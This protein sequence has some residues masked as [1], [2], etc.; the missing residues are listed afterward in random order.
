MKATVMCVLLVFLAGATASA[1]QDPSDAIYDQ[2]QVATFGLTMDRASWDAICYD[3]AGAGDQWHRAEMTWQS[4]T[5]PGVGVK[6]SG[7]GTR[8]DRTPKPAIRISFNEFEYSNPAGPG[9]PGR[10]WRGVNRIK[11]DNGEAGDDRAMMR[12]RVAYGLFRGIGAPAPRT[13]HARLYV[14]GSYIGLFTVEEPVRKDFLRYHRG[15]DSGNLYNVY[16]WV[17]GWNGT[18]PASYV[19]DPWVAETNYPGGDYTDVVR[20]CDVINNASLDQ[21]RARLANVI[22]VDG[23]LRHLAVEKVIVDH[24]GVVRLSGGTNNHFWY[25]RAATDRLE[26][27]KWDPGASQ[28]LGDETVAIDHNFDS[29]P[30][31]RWIRNDAAAWDAYK[32]WIRRTLDGPAAGIQAR[33]D[34]IYDQIKSHA[35]EDTLKGISATWHPNGF[36]NAEF[37]QGVVDLK[38][39]YTRRIAYL[40]SVVGGTS[41]ATNDAQYVSQNVPGTMTPGQT[42]SVTVVMKNAGT[43]T[44]TSAETYHL[45]SQNPPANFTWGVDRATLASGD[46]IAPGQE[47]AFTWNV[48]A[49]ATA[50]TYAFQWQM[51]QS[52]AN[53]WFG[54]LTPNVGVVVSDTAPPPP[55]GQNGLAGEYYDTMDLTGTPLVRVDRT[56]DFDW[57]AGSPDASIGA[58][59]FSVRWTGRVV[60]EF[61]ETYTFIANFNNGV[62]LWVNGTL[63]IDS[64]VD[65]WTELTGTIDL[66]AG[67]AADLKVEYYENQG[68]AMARLSW[69]SPSVPREVIPEGRLSP[70]PGGTQPAG[71]DGGE[72]GGGCGA[73]GM[74]ATLLVG[75]L[76]LRRRRPKEPRRS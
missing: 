52:S 38:E 29:M 34:S 33:I 43:T 62:R 45:R 44:W 60:P 36:T 63:L 23:F 54:D 46:S 1:A 57:G 25:H 65:A 13:C 51:R 20:F 59:T 42:Y 37:D 39:F 58:D 72:G 2:S 69:S 24:D 74:E 47:K 22:D 5:V 32:T 30:H 50:G 71:G 41:T 35:Y 18:D 53:D 4:D 3:G 67:T 10:K 14:N 7:M 6:R 66:V 68:N 12:D 21:V 31:S 70:V 27:I 73:T 15:E 11:L 76:G 19:P 17:Y 64:W 55:S 49:P 40:R 8:A 75:L 61:T 28:W 16:Q 26:I 48:T 56:L 9:T